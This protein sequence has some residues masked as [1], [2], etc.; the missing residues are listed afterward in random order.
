M[1]NFSSVFE[2]LKAF[3]DEQ[4]CID[5]L[6]KLR[7]N[8]N[9]VSPFDPDSKVYKCKGNRYRCKNTKKYF[10][11]KTSTIFEDTKIPL[12]KWFMALYL[13]SS[14]KK[15]ISSHQL[16]KDIGVTQKTAWFLL[17]RLRYAF[18]H[19][20]FKN[21]VGNSG[22][23]IDETFVGGKEKNKHRSKRNKETKRANDK[24]IVFGMYARNGNI[25]TMHIE[26]LKQKTIFP[27]II[28]NI[29]FLSKIYTDDF[30]V[31]RALKLLGWKHFYVN[32]SAN[33]YVKGMAHTNNIECYW[34]HFK[35]GL[36]GIYHWVS[37]KHLQSY[38]D[39]FAL[40]FNTRKLSTQLRFN[41]I[42]ENMMGRLTYKRLVNNC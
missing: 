26:N 37:S 25:V 31:Y 34:S 29:P 11:V 42:L 28:N 33:E 39:E 21:I 2:L 5:H 18:N 16:A 15:G 36:N 3:P 19:P 17:H 27:I 1:D 20:N 40:R 32:H 6:E 24:S 7:W 35:R 9:V 8:S 4:T 14:H 38:S 12:Q 30:K 23:E 22:T 10:N 41:L 13:F